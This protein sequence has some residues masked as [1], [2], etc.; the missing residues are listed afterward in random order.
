MAKRAIVII[1]D[2]VGV[3]ELPDAGDY[4][5][6]GSDTIGNLARKMGGLELPNLERLGFG[7]I[8]PIEGVACHTTPMANFGKMAEVS[9]GK[10]STT[11]HWELGGIIL[12]KAFPTYPNGFPESVIFRFKQET[13][14][15]ILGNYPASGTEIIKEL[16]GE[17]LRTGKPIVYTSADSVFQIAAHDEII[18]LEKLYEICEISRKILSGEHAV[19]RVIARPFTGKN[20]DDFARTK[21]RK[22]FSL[23]PQGETILSNLQNAGI[24]TIAIGK[25]NDLYAHDGISDGNPTK[26]NSEGMLALTAA[27]EKYH[28]GLIMA[29]LVD[30]DMLWGHRNDCQGFSSGL[31]SF[32]SWLGGFIDNLSPSDILIITSDHGNDPTTPSTDHS[33]EFVP[34]LV[35]GKLLKKG[36]NI[37]ERR[38]F[39][40][41]QATLAEYFSVK[42]TEWGESFLKLII[43]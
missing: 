10:D 13:G 19:A 18:P 20:R 32:D 38:S 21:Y 5:D 30:F 25:I 7:C 33:R 16:G 1:I 23:K 4:G 35:Y 22:D 15:D 27:L 14:L 43:K 3:G 9:P 2:G 39:A 34:L 26:T 8:H 41:L 6:T 40:D 11:G 29:N 37:G 36:V 17:H 28:D 42:K 12:K 31:V 24:P